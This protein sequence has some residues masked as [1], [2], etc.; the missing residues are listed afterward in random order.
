M[1]W[2]KRILLN[3]L[4]LVCILF[5]PWWVSAILILWYIWKFDMLEVIFYAML[6]DILYASYESLSAIHYPLL[7][8]LGFGL[9]VPPFPIFTLITALIVYIL[10]LVKKRIRF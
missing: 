3:S 8:G 7:F 2:L 6:M 4:L 9:E 10:S 1:S 5:L